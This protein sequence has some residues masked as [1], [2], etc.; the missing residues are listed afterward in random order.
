MNVL[1]IG[2]SYT[3]Y[4][5]MPALLEKLCKENGKDTAVCS[6]TKGGRKLESYLDPEDEITR[7]LDTAL[8]ENSF[9][10]C[11]IQEQ[12]VLP[13]AEFDT[14]IKG[15]N[16]VVDKVKNK[17]D[18]LVLYA[19]WGRQAGHPVLAEHG[20]TTASMTRLLADAYSRAAKQ[21]GADLSPV[22]ENFLYVTE[23]YPDVNLYDADKTHPSYE[24]SCL[25]ALTH[26]HTLFGAFPVHTA[27]LAL[28][29][30]TLSAFRAAVC[31]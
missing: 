7:A 24:G 28:S 3:Y 11:F 18:R 4:H 20:W 25:A 21:V 23:Q 31:R 15:L 9:D 10:I 13:A 8:S 27:S 16:C 29:D 5:D 17:A 1:F 14:F 19:T 2:N 22:G 12:S 6:I 26:Y 30:A